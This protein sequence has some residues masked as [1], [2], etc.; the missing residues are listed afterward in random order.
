MNTQPK[1]LISVMSYASNKSA[2]P[3]ATNYN[4][5]G[6]MPFSPEASLVPINK[7]YNYAKK[8]SVAN[9]KR[10]IFGKPKLLAQDTTMYRST[11]GKAINMQKREQKAL[12]S[13]TL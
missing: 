6:T 7:H 12:M 1:S 2:P 11:S 10:T 3:G 5:S 4:L 13:T 8:T 9:M